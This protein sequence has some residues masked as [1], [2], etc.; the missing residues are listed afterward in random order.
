MSDYYS[1]GD[2]QQLTMYAGTRGEIEVCDTCV[3]VLG[4][5]IRWD[6][7]HGTWHE[8]RGLVRP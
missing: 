3:N 1:S 8:E 7:A 4:L 5:N 2:H 6:Q